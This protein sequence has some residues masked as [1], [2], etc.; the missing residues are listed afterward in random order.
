MY[1]MNIIDILCWLLGYGLF[2]IFSALIINGIYITTRGEEET[3]PDGSKGSTNDMIFYPFYQLVTKTKG[4][5]F[6][7]YKNEELH[8]LT[9]R[10]LKKLPLPQPDLIT[11]D[12]L[13]YLN[14]RSVDALKLWSENAKEFLE[15]E[16]IK[17]SMA[18]INEAIEPYGRIQFYKQYPIYVLPKMLRK[19]LIECIKCMSSIW[20]SLIFWPVVLKAFPFDWIMIPCWIAY[21]FTLSYANTF[22]YKRS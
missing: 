5:R 15:G 11:E 6:I 10:I 20:G 16:E 21:C 4:E 13:H 19:P 12:A 7:F 8:T 17:M 3:L 18:L 2:I 9:R 22:L 14:G 1:I